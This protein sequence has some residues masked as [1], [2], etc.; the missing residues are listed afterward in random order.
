MPG[1][2]FITWHDVLAG[3]ESQ[4]ADRLTLLLVE[5]E[6]VDRRQGGQR[7]ADQGGDKG[8]DGFLVVPG[9]DGLPGSLS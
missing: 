8:V 1:A 4:E 3:H 2:F 5:I 9:T 6:S 7:I